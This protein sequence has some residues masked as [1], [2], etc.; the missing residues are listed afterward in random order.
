VE[1][2]IGNQVDWLWGRDFYRA[3]PSCTRVRWIDSCDGMNWV[4][5]GRLEVLR[6]FWEEIETSFGEGM[7]PLYTMTGWPN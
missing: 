3:I 1:I 6:L 5:V 2:V 4:R 7:S